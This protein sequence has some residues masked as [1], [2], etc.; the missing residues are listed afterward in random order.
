MISHSVHARSVLSVPRACGDLGVLLALVPVHR[1][2]ND[3]R[4]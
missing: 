1:V 4:H 2:H 3:V